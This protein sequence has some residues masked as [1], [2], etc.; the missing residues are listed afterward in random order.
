MVIPKIAVETVNV[1]QYSIIDKQ[2]VG[3]HKREITWE[4]LLP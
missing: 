2:A 3:I 1:S 4:D